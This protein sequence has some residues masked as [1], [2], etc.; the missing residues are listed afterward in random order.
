MPSIRLRVALAAFVFVT[1][2]MA[3]ER[4][5]TAGKVLD[6]QQQPVAAAV[7]TFSTAL[8]PHTSM[9]APEVLT[10]TT[11]AAGAF[12]LDVLAGHAYAAGAV[13]PRQPDGTSGVSRWTEGVRAG[14]FVVVPLERVQR[15]VPFEV[16]GLAAWGTSAPQ[17][18]RVVP[19]HAPGVSLEAELQDGRAVLPPMPVDR[20]LIE[21]CDANGD[22]VAAR[23]VAEPIAG[24]AC[25]VTMPAPH[26]LR[27]Q[28]HDGGGAPLAGV[29][30]EHR[31]V[32]HRHGNGIVVDECWREAWRRVGATD[33]EGRLD[34]RVAIAGCGWL[35]VFRAHKPGLAPSLAAIL[36]GTQTI[37][38]RG[39]SDNDCAEL[40][41]TL[42]EQRPLTGKLVRGADEPLAAD[43]WVELTSNLTL[44]SG[45]QVQ[46]PQLFPVRA[47][48]RGEWRLVD[49][50]DVFETARLLAPPALR[51]RNG[52]QLPFV[53]V[54]TSGRVTTLPTVALA[55]L[56]TLDLQVL[57][58]DGGP[59]EQAIAFVVPVD[60]RRW[61]VETWDAR[62]GLDRAGRARISVPGGAALLFCTDGVEFVEHRID[63]NTAKLEL[64]MAPLVQSVWTVKTPA[65]E[66]AAGAATEFTAYG[67]A[68]VRERDVWAQARGALEVSFQTA[69]ND[70]LRADSAGRMVLRT[71]PDAGLVM[72]L[73]LVHATGK[74]ER[75]R[76]AP[77][78]RELVLAK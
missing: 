65:G 3:Q 27:L 60:R 31:T 68:E 39:A 18:L 51:R 74:L 16:Q 37:D 20:L 53:L 63:G 49:A 8:A 15:D 4:R 66:P 38:A 44:P 43:L 7:V 35:Q 40:H 48:E 45:G 34:A 77:G 21:L 2:A 62:H 76:F 5:A 73:N 72:D 46:V 55:Q 6:A 75:V 19:V 54:E 30:I 9:A 67:S 78:D 28:V 70:G 24:R 11:D 23:E 17:R 10:A 71:L 56:P 64:R 13:G 41:F 61:F 14:Q 69:W 50:T 59:A 57:R 12:R 33:A 26:R 32:L 42:A 36:G 1:V 25:V 52:T 29:A 47:N 58:A 22:V